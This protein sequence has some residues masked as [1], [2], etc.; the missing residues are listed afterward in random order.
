[1]PIKVTFDQQAP[2]GWC[3]TCGH[4]IMW[5]STDQDEANDIIT[6][7]FTCPNCGSFIE[8]SEPLEEEKDN[9]PYR[10][11]LKQHLLADNPEVSEKDAESFVEIESRLNK[12]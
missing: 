12:E 9:Y 11:S 1:M 10:K 6:N 3:P 8:V 7:S 2:F 4:A 5:N